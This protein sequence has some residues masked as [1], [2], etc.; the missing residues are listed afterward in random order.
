MGAM[1]LF[2]RKV[3]LLQTVTV[4]NTIESQSAADE[5]NEELTHFSKLS[6]RPT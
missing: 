6:F 2:W 5:T 4:L 3:L 1:D